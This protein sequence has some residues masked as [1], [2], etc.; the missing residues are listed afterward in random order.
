MINNR[1]NENSLLVVI[2]NKG[3]GSKVLDYAMELG[4]RGATAFHAHGAVSNHLFKLLEIEDVRKEVILIAVPTRYEKEIVNKLTE[5]FSFN[6]PNRGISF[7]LDLT[8]VWGSSHFGSEEIPSSEMHHT[9]FLQAVLTIV[10]K[11]S[12]DTILDFIEEQGFPRGTVIDAQGSADMSNKFFDLIIEPEKDII[13]TITTREEA[14]RLARTLTKY[15][16]LESSNT[17]ILAILNI[18]HYVGITLTLQTSREATTP[19]EDTPGYSAI[20]AIVNNDKD[21]AVIL[22][23]EAAG[24]TGGTIIHAR[25][26]S[27]YLGNNKW[28]RGVEP[29]R[30]VVMII[31]RDENVQ[32]ICQRINSDLKLEQSGNGIIFVLPLYDTV[33]IISNK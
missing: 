25:G 3:K 20:F 28:S 16:D 10:D 14:H 18:K 2:V 8:G 1:I 21:Q 9:T 4:I 17:G 32:A 13:L 30:E 7:S 11:G 26:T 19:V 6:R 27:S 23:A 5:K 24:S 31:A 12:T 29:E 33:G 15:L 22:S